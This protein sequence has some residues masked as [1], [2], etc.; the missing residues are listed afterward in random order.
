M[1]TFR[2]NDDIWHIQEQ[3]FSPKMLGFLPDLISNLYPGNVAEQLER[4]YAH[5]GGYRDLTKLEPGKWT[6]NKRNK[7]LRYRGESDIFNPLASV[8]IK[9][10][11]VYF[12]K[13]SLLAIVKPDGS[14]AVTRVD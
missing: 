10:E 3:R 11:M 14:F 5:G 4:N 2:I 1:T 6:F 12:Y 8:Q 9:D 7:T 13:Y